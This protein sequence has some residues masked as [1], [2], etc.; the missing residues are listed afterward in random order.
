MEDYELVDLH[1]CPR[2]GGASLLEEEIGSGYYVTCVDCGSH[3][4]TV[5]FKNEEGRKT[6]IEKAAMLWNF[7]KVISSH[8]GE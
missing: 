1:D 2:C 6:A 5:D 7:G 8:P 4:V 3:T